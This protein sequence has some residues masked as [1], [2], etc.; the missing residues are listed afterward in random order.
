MR[1]RTGKW[2][3][4]LTAV[5][6][7]GAL[8]ACKKDKDEEPAP[9]ASAPPPAPEPPKEEEKPAEAPADKDAVKRYGDKEFEEKGTV[10]ITVNLAKIYKEADETTDH[11]A[12][13][14]RG[15][16]VNKLARMGNYTL[17]EYPTG[18]G[19]LSPAWILSKHISR[20]VVAD[21][22][23]EDVA[24]QDAGVELTEAGKAAAEAEEKKEATTDAGTTARTDAAAATPDAGTKTEDA[25]APTTDASTVPPKLRVPVPLKLPGN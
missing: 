1:A 22:K 23:P 11:L 2:T 6:V 13:L 10:R 4:A 9:I 7:M 8:L 3:T 24:K 17:I 12:R 18:V 19:K 21:V 15:T 14:N 5:L 25:A 20:Q 16:L